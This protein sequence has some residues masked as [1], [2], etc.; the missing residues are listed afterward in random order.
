M[1]SDYRP[2]KLAK[3]VVHAVECLL[4][5]EKGRQK[6]QELM[7]TSE[8]PEIRLVEDTLLQRKQVLIFYSTKK[9]RGSGRGKDCRSTS[10]AS[11]QGRNWQ[12]SKG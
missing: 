2:V 9:E 3:G 6:P 11:S 4:R 8:I 7:G 12:S 5:C 1:E 10:Q